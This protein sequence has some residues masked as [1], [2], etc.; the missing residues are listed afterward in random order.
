M[1]VKHTGVYEFSASSSPLACWPFVKRS[2]GFSSFK[3]TGEKHMQHI[4]PPADCK[5]NVCQKSRNVL[6]YLKLAGTVSCHTAPFPAIFCRNTAF[7]ARV[8]TTPYLACT[9]PPCKSRR[10]NLTRLCTLY[11]IVFTPSPVQ[12]SHSRQ[13]CLR[14]LDIRGI[15]CITPPVP[16]QACRKHGLF[17]LPQEMRPC[18][19]HPFFFK[20]KSL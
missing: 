10:H 6:Y 5:A 20:K 4:V 17:R 12:Y 3:S 19:K 18:R 11:N 9:P 2:A 13:R 15:R 16:W 14:S 1:Y 7:L 8:G